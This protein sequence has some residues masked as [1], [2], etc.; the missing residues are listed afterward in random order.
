MES[1]RELEAG[2]HLLCEQFV[3]YNALMQQLVTAVG[4]YT[5]LY[6]DASVNAYQTFRK[7]KAA[8]RK[9]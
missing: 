4:I 3:Q 9:N 7:A 8:K 5:K 2:I 1:Q 6:N